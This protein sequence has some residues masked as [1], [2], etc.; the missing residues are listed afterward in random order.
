MFTRR[1]LLSVFKGCIIAGSF[2]TGYYAF[3]RW[4]N[5]NRLEHSRP[6][7]L[8]PELSLNQARKK[9][10]PNGDRMNLV[11]IVLDCWR[12]DHFSPDI[13]PWLWKFAD[14]GLKFTN[15][16][17][18]AGYTRASA[19]SYF[20]GRLPVFE[21]G[22]TDYD[23]IGFRYLSQTKQ[24]Q[25]SSMGEMIPDDFETFPKLFKNSSYYRTVAGVQNQLL[26]YWGGYGKREWDNIVQFELTDYKHGADTLVR[27]TLGLLNAIRKTER[28]VPFLLYMHFVDAHQPYNRVKLSDKERQRQESYFKTRDTGDIV[29]RKRLLPEVKENYLRGLK[30]LDR[31][32]ARLVD[33]INDLEDKSRDTSFMIFA[34]HGEMFN[35]TGERWNIGHSGYIPLEIM[36]VPFFIVGKGFTARINDEL[37]EGIDLAPTVLNL[38]GLSQTENMPGR[39]LIWDKG[40]DS[41]FSYSPYE[42]SRIIKKGGDIEI[43]RE[44]LA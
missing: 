14:R 1:E 37:R 2:G 31:Q 23:A 35:E 32:I 24:L 20:S 19:A 39:N 7:D 4:Q 38:A 9:P 6:W 21:P 12:Y 40:R 26:T 10:D 43:R 17:V 5:E 36:H 8:R 16:Y 25:R 11:L 29:L 15:F 41:I 13:T 3:R 30:F 33:G 28:D 44:P 27:E 22:D 42:T 34:D 18:N